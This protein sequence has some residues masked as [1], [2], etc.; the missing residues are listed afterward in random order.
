MA[1]P[2]NP[3]IVQSDKSVLLETENLLY[4]EAR[5][6]LAQFAELVKSPEHIHTYRIT[7]LS[8]WNA[9][10]SGTTPEEMIG[11]LERYGKYELPE[12]VRVDILDYVGR[13]GRIRME[14]RENTIVLTSADDILITEI[15]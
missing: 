7:P 14:K 15:A 13:Y 4:E 8:L 11:V 1:N 12:N 2:Q 6:G 5:D 10:A 9:A 3:L